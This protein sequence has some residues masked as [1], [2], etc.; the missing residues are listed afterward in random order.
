MY[1]NP[2]HFKIED[3]H[4][5]FKATGLTRTS[6]VIDDYVRDVALSE[7]ERVYGHFEGGLAHEFKDWY[8]L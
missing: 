8:G 1:G 3:N 2:A 6:Y 5:N 4:P 7:I